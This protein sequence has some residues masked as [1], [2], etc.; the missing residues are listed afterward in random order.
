MLTILSSIVNIIVGG[1]YSVL[2]WIRHFWLWKIIAALGELRKV[3]RLLL[4]SHVTLQIQRKPNS[5]IQVEHHGKQQKLGFAF[6]KDVSRLSMRLVHIQ[7]TRITVVVVIWQ[8]FLTSHPLG[9]YT[10]CTESPIPSAANLGQY[11]NTE[12]PNG[13]KSMCYRE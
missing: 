8:P 2:F 13:I 9:L 7:L 3:H 10:E 5:H 1:S 12:F 4:K 6:S 11:N